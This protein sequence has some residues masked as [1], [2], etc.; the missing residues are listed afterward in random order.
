MGVFPNIQ[1]TAPMLRTVSFGLQTT[2]Y[3]GSFLKFQR[4]QEKKPPCTMAV[5]GTEQGQ[6]TGLPADGG[7]RETETH[8]PGHPGH[9]VWDSEAGPHPR[10]WALPAS[11]RRPPECLSPRC[12]RQ[13]GEKALRTSGRRGHSSARGWGPGSGLVARCRGWV[14][15]E[16]AWSTRR[17]RTSAGAARERLLKKQ[18]F[19]PSRE[20]CCHLL[21][22]QLTAGNA[23]IFCIKA[24]TCWKLIS[25][26]KTLE[27]VVIFCL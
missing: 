13:A 3:I 22:S 9:P 15:R 24:Q 26:K 18:Y 17:A 5:L 1:T 2:V 23:L 10:A 6:A 8:S 11:L 27:T 20:T 4:S 25:E 12:H 16:P 19:Y 21:K 7:A 14:L